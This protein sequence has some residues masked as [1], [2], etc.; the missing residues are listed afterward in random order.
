MLEE[1]IQWLV[2][3]GYTVSFEPAWINPA[4]KVFQ[5]DCNII[6]PV[7]TADRKVF[8]ISATNTTKYTATGLEH[9]DGYALNM[10]VSKVS[11]LVK[12]LQ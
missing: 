10:I 5:V 2:Q 12:A 9:D 11:A 4:G 3:H 8:S 1:S 7:K 6:A